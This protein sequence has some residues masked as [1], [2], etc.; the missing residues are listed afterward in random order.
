MDVYCHQ[1]DFML[2]KINNLMPNQNSI[3]EFDNQI[4]YFQGEIERLNFEK[5]SVMEELTQYQH[6]Q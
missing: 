3:P 1:I 5:L 6:N 2:N 4:V